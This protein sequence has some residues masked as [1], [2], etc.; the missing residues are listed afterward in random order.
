[1]NLGVEQLTPIHLEMHGCILSTVAA[2]ALVLMH[3][4]IIIHSADNI[5]TVMDQF[6]TKRI[7]LQ[8][9]GF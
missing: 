3:H 4:T 9:K 7:H 6:H 5:F 2:D 8:Q 1:M